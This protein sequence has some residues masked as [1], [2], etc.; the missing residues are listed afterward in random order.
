MRVAADLQRDLAAQLAEPGEIRA[1][2]GL[3]QL[4]PD[5]ELGRALG[6]APAALDDQGRSAEVV[7]EMIEL[8]RDVAGVEIDHEA[9]HLQDVRGAGLARSPRPCRG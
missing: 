5:M 1:L 2:R 6:R 7:D 4:P 8:G 3:G 9:L